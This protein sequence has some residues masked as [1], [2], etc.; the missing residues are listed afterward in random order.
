VS[1][2]SGIPLSTVLNCSTGFIDG[3]VAA[4]WMM[5][6]ICWCC[7]S[8]FRDISCSIVVPV[9]KTCADLLK[10]GQ[11]LAKALLAAK[12]RASQP[13][14]AT[15]DAFEVMN[16]QF[17]TK[18]YELHVYQLRDANAGVPEGSLP[19]QLLLTVLLF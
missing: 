4:G 6:D 3:L 12:K 1:G 8:L 15:L 17:I 13:T 11:A 5:A 14:R 7:E 9:H 16:V 19:P 18:V 10:A 2:H